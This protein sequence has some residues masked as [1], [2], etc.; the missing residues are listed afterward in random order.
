L[1]RNGNRFDLYIDGVS[2]AN[3]T[4]A[5]T[6]LHNSNSIRLG[7]GYTV[8]EYV[9]GRIDECR[10]SKGI[11]RWTQNFIP[12]DRPFGPCEPTPAPTASPTAEPTLTP[13]PLP[14]LNAWHIPAS[15]EACGYD[16]PMRNVTLPTDPGDPVCL[17]TGVYPIG[18]ASVLMVYYRVNDGDWQARGFAWTCNDGNNDYWWTACDDPMERWE[19]GAS[20]GDTVS[21]YIEVEGEGCAPTY[22]FNEAYPSQTRSQSEAMANPYWF[23]YPQSTPTPL[24]TATAVPS[25]TPEPTGTAVPCAHDGDANQDGAVTPGDAQTAFFCYLDCAGLNPSRG[26]YCAADFCGND[27]IEPCSGDV[28]PADAQGIMRFYL[29]YANPCGKLRSRSAPTAGATL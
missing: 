11:A 16:A 2:Q 28:T 13:S 10:I 3:I 25:A 1:V 22:L 9:T 7:W 4:S 27:V 23:T 8:G 17:Y 5:I 18:G 21:Y 26:A 29:G 19:H 12:P 20:G 6:V 15:A 24:P 14:T